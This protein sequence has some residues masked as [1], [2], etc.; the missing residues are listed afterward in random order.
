MKVGRKFRA[1]FADKDSKAAYMTYSAGQALVYNACAEE[2][3]YFD[4]FAY[5]YGETQQKDVR[6]VSER[7]E[8]AR[9]WECFSK[10]QADQKYSHL[11]DDSLVPW[12][13]TVPGGVLCIGAYLHYQARLRF[14]KGL[15]SRPHS[16]PIR[17]ADRSLMLTKK[18]FSIRHHENNWY[19]LSFG[20]DRIKGGRILFRAHR[21]FEMPVTVVIS[22]RTNSLSVSFCFEERAELG[23]PETEEEIF[24]RLKMLSEDELL[25]RTQGFDRGVKIPLQS[26][27]NRSFG[28]SEVQEKRMLEQEEKR[29]KLQQKLARQQKG[30]NRYRK[31]RKKINKTYKYARN[32][33]NDVAHKAS[34]EVVSDD[35]TD[36]YAFE[37]LNIP[38]MT[39]SPD[40][41][42][43]GDGT[44]LPNG[45]A[46][47]AGLN[48]AILRSCWGRF[49]TFTKYKALRAHKLVIEV[50]AK[51]SSRECSVCHCTDSRNRPSQAVFR[52]I[53]CGFE[54]NADWNASEVIRM[55]GVKL[56]KSGKWSP[57]KAKKLLRVKSAKPN[58]PDENNRG[59]SLQVY[60][61]PAREQSLVGK[62]EEA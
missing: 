42:Y 62:R 34:H 16:K 38:G 35:S 13:R 14:L 39:A 11:I 22:C 3:R 17:Q 57:K 12:V 55:R 56:L 51:N 6:P 36:L 5:R 54:A 25:V 33:C 18:F 32:V 31:T 21:E 61:R 40:P 29:I 49:L 53:A 8:P 26:S 44:P 59:G 48:K 2:A 4:F 23:F 10:P 46:A 7:N 58:E 50:P 37:K 43:D 41:K 30:S 1:K 60:A 15:T 9:R 19:E 20:T 52:C 45:A 27:N 28:F 47:K 24:E